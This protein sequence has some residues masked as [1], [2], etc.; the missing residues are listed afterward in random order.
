LCM[1]IEEGTTAAALLVTRC[2]SDIL[3][4]RGRGD[5]HVGPEGDHTPGVFSVGE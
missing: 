4:Q 5:D 2:V 3:G 1:V